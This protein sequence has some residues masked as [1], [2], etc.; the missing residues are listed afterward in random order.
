LLRVNKPDGTVIE[1][2]IDAANR[3]VGKKVNGVL[4]QR[5]IYTSGPGRLRSSTRTVT[6]SPGWSMLRVATYPI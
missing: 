1:Y 4:V 5:F 2:V 6:F 3:R